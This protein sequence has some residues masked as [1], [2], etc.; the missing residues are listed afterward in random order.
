M[1]SFWN[2]DFCFSA[3]GGWGRDVAVEFEFEGKFGLEKVV[4]RVKCACPI[5]G[6][7]STVPETD[8]PV[9]DT[10]KVGLRERENT[11]SA[12][13]LSAS[14]SGDRS[15]ERDP[16]W[17]FLLIPRSSIFG[18]RP[19]PREEVEE[20]DVCFCARSFTSWIDFSRA[21]RSS[22]RSRFSSARDVTSWLMTSSWTENFCAMSSSCARRL[23][24]RVSVSSASSR[25][26]S[27]SDCRHRRAR[28]R[29]WYA[30][31]NFERRAREDCCRFL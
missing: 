1:S 15:R 4:K 22:D 23:R 31:W 7:D 28:V 2:V 11:E 13:R 5:S 12:F 8:G 20:V 29:A 16:W 26:T 14:E 18:S 10:V 30:D 6:V 27:V 3:F 19:R 24:T 21:S 9:E 17:Y 25:E